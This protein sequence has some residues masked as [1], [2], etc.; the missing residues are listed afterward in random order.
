MRSV[1]RDPAFD[2][3]ARLLREGYTF[4]GNGCDR[5][6][7]DVFRTRLALRRTICLRGRDGAALFYDG[8]RFERRGAA[9]S[10]LKA[11]LLGRGGVQGLDGEDHLH[12]KA[13]FMGIVTPA[14]VRGRAAGAVRLRPPGRR[15]P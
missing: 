7:G 1:P 5:V 6:D 10:R 9:P 8:E 2:A 3:T 13:L 14:A 11:T 4:I 12:R 15:R